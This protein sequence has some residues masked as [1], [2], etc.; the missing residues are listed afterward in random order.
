M[1]ATKTRITKKLLREELTTLLRKVYAYS[2]MTDEMLR[3]EYFTVHP[4]D[5]DMPEEWGKSVLTRDV[6]IR[7]LIG[8]GLHYIENVF[9]L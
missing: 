7:S 6:M 8:S 5:R 3:E 1:T 9:D 4:Y 2:N